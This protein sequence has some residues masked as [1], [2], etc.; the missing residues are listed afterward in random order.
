[1]LQNQHREHNLVPQFINTQSGKLRS[2]TLTLG[3]RADSYYEYLFK[4]WLQSG[5]TEDK[6]VLLTGIALS[7]F[8]VSL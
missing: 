8:G 3:S 7:L 1:M 6:Y 2:G 5:K 4:Q